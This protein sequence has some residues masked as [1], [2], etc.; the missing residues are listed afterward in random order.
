[1]LFILPVCCFLVGECFFAHKKQTHNKTSD[2]YKNLFHD[3]G[4]QKYQSFSINLFIFSSNDVTRIVVS[5]LTRPSTTPSSVTDAIRLFF[6]SKVKSP[7]VFSTTNSSVPSW[8][9]I[10]L[11]FVTRIAGLASSFEQPI[12][13]AI[14]DTKKKYFFISINLNCF[15]FA[16]RYIAVLTTSVN[17]YFSL[18][19]IQPAKK[20][21]FYAYLRFLS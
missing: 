4:I 16:Q 13:R 12:K 1:M 14:I 6:D 2:C 8:K 15:I 17:G 5:P 19:M 10:K 3:I 18:K 20:T 11:L 21:A 9:R 7:G